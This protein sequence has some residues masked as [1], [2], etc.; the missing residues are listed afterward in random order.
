MKRRRPGSQAERALAEAEQTT[1]PCA[2]RMLANRQHAIEARRARID[3]LYP[4]ERT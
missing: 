3:R 2:R 1:I 4:H